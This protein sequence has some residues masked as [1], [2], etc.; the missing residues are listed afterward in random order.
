M[1]KISAML[2]ATL[3]A[4]ALAGTASAQ[5]LLDQQLGGEKAA[6]PAGVSPTPATN[7][8]DP[9]PE[10]KPD[11]KPANGGDISSPDA[12]KKIDDEDLTNKLLHPDEKPDPDKFKQQMK[13][14]LE[15]MDQVENLLTDKKDP[16]ALTQETERRIIVDLDA[17]IEM[18]KQMNPPP[19]NGK[20]QPGDDDPDSGQKKKPSSGNQ[21]GQPMPGQQNTGGNT[22]AL[23]DQLPGNNQAAADPLQDI[24]E[25]ASGWG[26]LRPQERDLI[27]HGAR[28][29][30]VNSYRDLINRYYNAL[31]ELGKTRTR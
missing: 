5:S 24:H 23:K 21:A 17:M 6:L 10:A 13:E 25:K 2:A 12:V 7:P 22:A 30:Y 28:E 18:A 9:K 20:P 4:A 3:I 15:R 19:G 16:G 26:G 29:D 8:A 31:G 27:S 14:A 11:V 1:K